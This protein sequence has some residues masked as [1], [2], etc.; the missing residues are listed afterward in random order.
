MASLF[1][2]SKSFSELF[3]NLSLITMPMG[4]SINISSDEKNGTAVDSF[5]IEVDWKN[6]LLAGR[7]PEVEKIQQVIGDKLV[8]A[9]AYRGKRT[10]LAFGPRAVEHARAMLED[11]GF[12]TASTTGALLKEYPLAGEVKI[13]SIAKLLL[14][15]SVPQTPPLLA[16]SAMESTTALSLTAKSD[17]SKAMFR[18]SVPAP[19]IRAFR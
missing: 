9:A 17:G 10:A 12:G 1:L 8:I 11:K 16:L 6:A 5:S 4:L 19:V 3:R 15:H 14:K 7:I 13:A 2:K 18:L